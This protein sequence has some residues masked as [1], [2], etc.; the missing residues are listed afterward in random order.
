MRHNIIFLDVDGVLNSMAYFETGEDV[1]EIDMTAVERLAKIYHDCDCR[2]VLSST[3]RCLRGSERKGPHRMYEYLEDCLAKYDMK[4]MDITP[5]NLQN[6]PGEIAEWLEKNKEKV[7]NFVS[8]DDDFGEEHY[9][10]HGL[11]GH[12]VQTLFYTHDVTKGGIQDKHVKKAKEILDKKE[13]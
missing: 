6:R 4:I 9:K 5:V 1:P 13:A 10:K 7:K 8:L 12:L 11:G 3:W 2:I